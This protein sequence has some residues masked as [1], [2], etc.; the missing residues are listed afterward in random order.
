MTEKVYIVWDG[1]YSDKGILAVFLTEEGGRRLRPQT[2]AR[3]SSG[4]GVLETMVRRS[5][6]R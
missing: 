5:L 2:Q 6:C 3:A 4:D 1:A